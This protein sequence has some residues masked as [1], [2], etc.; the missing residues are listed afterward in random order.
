MPLRV[1]LLLSGC[2]VSD[3]AEIH[4]SVLALLAIAEIG[5]EAVCIGVDQPQHHVTNHLTGEAVNETRNML[6]EAAR[7]ARGN[8]KDVST[9]RGDDIDA[10]VIPGGFGS[11]CNLTTWAF[12]GPDGEIL[13]QVK[14]LL[15][16]LHSERKPIAGLCVSPVVIAKA[17]QDTGVAPEMTLGTDEQPSP[18]DI[19]GFS[20]GLSVAGAKAVYRKRDEIAVDEVNKIVTAPCYMMETDLPTLRKNILDAVTA[21]KKLV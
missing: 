2:G 15:Q 3:G 1:G 10:L 5:G 6:V 11:A 12:D 19:A 4:E 9:V 8:I 20:S 16:E 18:Y 21:I 14:R 13:P 17:L 7:I